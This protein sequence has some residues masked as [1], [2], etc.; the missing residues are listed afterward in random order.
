MVCWE[1]S[2]KFWEILMKFWWN[3][4]EGSGT[5]VTSKYHRIKENQ[6]NFMASNTDVSLSQNCSISFWA[7]AS[8]TSSVQRVENTLK[9]I[10]R[11]P[12]VILQWGTGAMWI[13]LPLAGSQMLQM[14]NVTRSAEC[15][16][17]VSIQMLLP[18]SLKNSLENVKTQDLH[19]P[20]CP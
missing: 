12:K 10:F 14:S 8:P 5:T 18:G 15:K 20:M 17:G 1:I 2:K 9:N 16:Q 11:P 7:L 3:T 6:N 13:V 4:K 19:K